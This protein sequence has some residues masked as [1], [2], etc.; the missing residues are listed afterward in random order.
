MSGAIFNY[1]S[2]TARHDLK[3][4]AGADGSLS[5]PSNIHSDRTFMI[6]LQRPLTSDVMGMLIYDRT[7]SF[8]GHVL[9]DAGPDV[10][11]A[12][13]RY[14]P[15]GSALKIYR[16]AKRVGDWELSVCMDREPDEKPQW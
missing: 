12:A 4:P 9:R 15:L 8:T 7:R 13:M 1:S 6:K 10:Y 3:M 14:M 2:S 11:D 5:P 16:W